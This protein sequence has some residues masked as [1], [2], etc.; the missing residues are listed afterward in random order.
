MLPVVNVGQW[1]MLQKMYIEIPEL[2]LK[3]ISLKIRG[4]QDREQSNQTS[5]HLWELHALVG[6]PDNH[7]T[8]QIYFI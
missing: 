4:E 7:P 3:I 1:Q 8:D 2:Y 5:S 6:L